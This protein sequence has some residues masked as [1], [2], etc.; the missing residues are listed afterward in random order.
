MSTLAI[1]PPIR[2]PQG[3]AGFTYDEVR[4]T[5]L[6]QHF[7]YQKALFVGDIRTAEKILNTKDVERL[8]QLA[9]R[10]AE[11]HAEE[12]WDAISPDVILQAIY[13][14]CL[15][16]PLLGDWVLAQDET[17]I[18]S[19]AS[20]WGLTHLDVT[21][22]SNASSASRDNRLGEALAKVRSLLLVK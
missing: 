1:E 4:Y 3:D 9:T 18:R 10:I 5:N 13:T 11:S 20:L 14:K 21:E 12:A 22:G 7:Y 15:Q 16:E 19:I 2:Y 17:A 6:A 8:R